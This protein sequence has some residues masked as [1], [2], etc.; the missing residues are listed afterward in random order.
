MEIFIVILGIV[1]IV[2]YV[3]TLQYNYRKKKRIDDAV[4]NYEVEKKEREGK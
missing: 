1:F 2:V 3:K 4:R